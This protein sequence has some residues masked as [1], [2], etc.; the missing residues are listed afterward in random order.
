MSVP[1]VREPCGELAPCKEK[2]MV[3]Y[4]LPLL[5]VVAVLIAALLFGILARTVRAEEG[6]WKTDFKG[7]LAKA[8]AEK[9][10]LLVDF[11]GSDWCG[12]CI[13]LH[14]EVFDKD[15]FKAAAPKQYVLVELDFP[16]QKELP[17]DLQKQNEELRDKYEIEGFPTVLLMDATG[18]VIARTGYRPGGPEEYLKQLAEFPKIYDGV[19]AAKTKLDAAAGLDRA[20]L[21]DEI[22]EGY[23][24]LGNNTKEQAEK[25]VAWSKEI[26]ALDADNKAGLKVKYEFP[27]K[28]A[29]AEKL[30][31][32]GKAAEARELLDKALALPGISADLRQEGYMSKASIC[33]SEGQFSD[34]LAALKAAK[35]A[36]PKSEHA[37]HIDELIEH[38]V[39]VAEAEKAVRKLEGELP[40]AK[41]LDRAKLLDKLVAAEEKLPET[42]AAAEKTQKWRKEVIALDADNKAGLKQKHQF[43]VAL[44]EALDL[45]RAEKADDAVAALDKALALPGVSGE[46]TQKAL[47]FKAQL[48]GAHHNTDEEL[49]CLKKALDAAPKS[50]IAPMLKQ[51]IE[52]VE[53]AKK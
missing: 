10:Y 9:K 50:E 39:Q 6:L 2:N 27:M 22:L 53:K 28:M 46:D 3:S 40:D 15:P 37:K 42:P 8:K 38:F 5:L 16:Q 1:D 52:Q 24:K 17:K 41:G 30:A 43:H 25:K 49:K 19:V 31:E 13:K 20:K 12:W 44:N 26:I 23:D 36:A 32:S 51:M 18:E 29:E 14:N 48:A 21:L 7:A 4:R 34:V 47:F 11:T 45:A 33:E 35:D